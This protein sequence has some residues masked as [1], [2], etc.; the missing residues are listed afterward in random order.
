[1]SQ[2]TVHE[3]VDRRLAEQV[4]VVERQDE[5][6]AGAVQVVQQAAGEDGGGRLLG[7]LEHRKIV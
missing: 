2:Q 1:M 5:A 4:V 7:G 6:L 3:L